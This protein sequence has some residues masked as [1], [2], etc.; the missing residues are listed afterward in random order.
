ME[1][2]PRVSIHPSTEEATASHDKIVAQKDRYTALIY[3]DGSGIQG[4]V[5]SAAWY[6]AINGFVSH[7]MG[8]DN[9]SNVYAAELMGIHSALNIAIGQGNRIKEVVIFTDN[10]AAILSSECPRNQSGQWIL[11]GIRQKLEHLHRQRKTVHLHWVPAHVGIEGNEEV[12]ILAKEA[13][14]WR[15][16][17][18]GPVGTIIPNR[19]VLYSANKRVL[20]Q[21]IYQKWQSSWGREKTG[22]QYRAYRG[23]EIDRHINKIHEGEAKH[24]SAII[25]Q[26]RTGKIGLNAYLHSIK[27]HDTPEC[28]CG[29]SNETVGHLLEDCPLYRDTRKAFLGRATMTDAMKLLN[30]RKTLIKAARFMFELNKLDQFKDVFYQQHID[31]EQSAE[32]DEE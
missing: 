19:D 3:T 13:T 12:D 10:Q 25:T 29:W 32:S 28:D 7:Y 1:R 8:L 6:P 22:K 24:F 21:G 14:G 31:Q 11:R 26:L 5:G 9:E 17:G 18:R 15:K 4:H 20:K 16:R 2:A 30:E 27:Q 23:L